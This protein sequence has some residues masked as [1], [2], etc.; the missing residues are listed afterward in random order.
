M[1]TYPQNTRDFERRFC[2]KVSSNGCDLW[3]YYQKRAFY[4]TA[5]YLVSK[6]NRGRQVDTQ[7][8]LSNTSDE[9]WWQ[10]FFCSK[11]IKMTKK[12]LIGSTKY[13]SSLS[14]FHEILSYYSPN[15]MFSRKLFWKY[16][17]K[18]LSFRLFRIFEKFFGSLVFCDESEPR[19]LLPPSRRRSISPPTQLSKANHTT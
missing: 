16:K 19:G 4:L 18:L 17:R 5:P 6:L 2:D 12:K 9:V 3:T 11:R 7:N 14:S 13:S 1:D 15:F 10:E 8:E